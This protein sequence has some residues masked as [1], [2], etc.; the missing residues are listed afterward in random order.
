ME[1]KMYRIERSIDSLENQAKIAYAFTQIEW[2][3]M[4][5]ACVFNR[6]PRHFEPGYIM[7]RD[8]YAAAIDGSES[9]SLEEFIRIYKLNNVGIQCIGSI[10]DD[11]DMRIGLSI[12]PSA[13]SGIDRGFVLTYFNASDSIMNRFFESLY[14][15]YDAL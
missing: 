9:L 3:N 6:H 1:P 13:M 5:E 2:L 10:N 14:E 12:L 15:K 4:P 7:P 11:D 8:I